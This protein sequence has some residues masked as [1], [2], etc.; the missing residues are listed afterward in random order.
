MS[1]F[2]VIPQG[3]FGSNGRK[4]LSLSSCGWVLIRSGQFKI[5]RNFAGVNLSLSRKGKDAATGAQ[6]GKTDRYHAEHGLAWTTY[7]VKLLILAQARRWLSA[8]EQLHPIAE[9]PRTPKT[10]LQLALAIKQPKSA[11]YVPFGRDFEGTDACAPEATPPCTYKELQ[12]VSLGPATCSSR[13]R[14]STAC[15]A[16]LDLAA[17]LRA[18]ASDAIVLK[19][20]IDFALPSKKRV[21]A[22]DVTARGPAG[23]AT[24][25]TRSIGH[26]TTQP[27]HAPS[28][29]GD[30][31]EHTEDNQGDAKQAHDDPRA[32]AALE[33]GTS[34]P[35]HA[36]SASRS[37]VD[38]AGHSEYDTGGETPKKFLR[39]HVHG[40]QPAPHVVTL[41][42]HTAKAMNGAQLLQVRRARASPTIFEPHDCWAN[43]G[44]MHLPQQ[45]CVVER[46]AYEAARARLLLDT[47]ASITPASQVHA[48]SPPHFAQNKHRTLQQSM[49]HRRCSRHALAAFAAKDSSTHQHCGSIA[50]SN[51]RQRSAHSGK[52]SN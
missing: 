9:A 16:S 49:F 34:A 21:D 30:A 20:L 8:T 32:S 36:G 7:H 22:G 38:A 47:Q 4:Q 29:G 45:T 26:G 33:H 15:L 10:N 48:P 23:V 42:Q 44:P 43:P 3:P 28:S 35:K 12:E 5:T 39:R 13:A 27:G 2:T 19:H 14:M 46:A 50:S 52:L 31:T 1:L 24:E 18:F 37:A 25:Y 6:E 40:Q 51:T 17:K 41:S 11:E